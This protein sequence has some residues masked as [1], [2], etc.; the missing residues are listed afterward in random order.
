[1]RTPYTRAHRVGGNLPV[2]DPYLSPSL[3]FSLRGSGS[4]SSAATSPTPARTSGRAASGSPSR[5]WSPTC[6]RVF[7]D[8]KIFPLARAASTK[9]ELCHVP[10]KNSSRLKEPPEE[11]LTTRMLD[12]CLASPHPSVNICSK[13]PES[14]V[15]RR[16]TMSLKRGL[17]K[18]RRKERNQKK[19]KKGRKGKNQRRMDKARRHF[20]WGKKNG[21]QSRSRKKIKR[22]KK[23]FK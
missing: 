12:S 21:K 3:V 22:R 2:T 4:S 11:I 16:I 1:M 18:I 23:V 8:Q 20:S 13:R 6:E 19:M 7:S 10:R 9:E 17:K 14:D 5:P 15:A